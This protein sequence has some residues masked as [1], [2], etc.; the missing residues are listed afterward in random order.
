MAPRKVRLVANLIKGQ[1]VSDAEVA[2]RFAARRPAEPLLK[3]LRSAVANAKHN[4]NLDKANL[5]VKNLT[6][7]K[8]PT[9]KRFMPRARG[10]ASPIRKRSSHITLVLETKK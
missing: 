1:R 7:D 10:M 3:L 9:L 5:F 4:S 6:V 8:G 2:L